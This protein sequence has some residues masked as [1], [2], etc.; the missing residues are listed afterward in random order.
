MQHFFVAATVLLSP[1][2]ASPHSRQ[3]GPHGFHHGK[4]YPPNFVNGTVPCA[5]G[6][7][8]VR[9]T[10]T[11]SFTGV[12]DS[13]AQANDE[14]GSTALVSVTSSDVPQPS[15]EI[16]MTADTI[17]AD[18]GC[19]AATV[20]ITVPSSTTQTVTVFPSGTDEALSA[21]L[22]T[23][24]DTAPSLSSAAPVAPSAFSIS[25][26]TSSL[27]AI[28]TFAATVANS[29]P[30]SSQPSSEPA[31]APLSTIPEKASPEASAPAPPVSASSTPA[32]N[33][34]IPQTGLPFKT[35]RGIIASGNS[36]NKLT[37]A[38]GTGKISWLGDWY[39]APPP[40]IPSTVHFVPQNYNKDSDAD[41]TFTRNA[42]SQI[43][44]GTKYLLSYGEP[45]AAKLSVDEVVQMFKKSMQPF[46]DEGI[47]VSSPTTLQTDS[48]FDWLESFLQACNGCS[49]DFLAI[50][51]MNSYNDGAVNEL[52][53][54]LNRAH[55]LATKFKI[56]GG[57]WL[58][59]F[60]VVGS[61]EQQKGF[62]QEIVPWLEA[63]DWIKAYAYVPDEVGRAGS[64][65]NFIGYNGALNELGQ[66]YANL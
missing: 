14:D 24:A 52:K 15:A 54:T 61:V 22:L 20:T 58:D 48:D 62:L 60:E 46:A 40:T 51:Y 30:A 3:K 56:P 35:K 21:I 27:A 64:G 4:K 11:S 33:A 57:I 5:I 34:P 16:I 31:A 45:A 55:D 39:S 43:A 25:N 8:L 37:A 53:N 38:I 65:P 18:S 32:A 2:L 1:V 47:A 19:A 44:K 66:F 49:I 36:Q 9:P 6:T 12:Y 29:A 28:P 23:T 63:Q 50:H 59:N 42:R 7:G 13:Y 26:E 41:G 17:N 10:G